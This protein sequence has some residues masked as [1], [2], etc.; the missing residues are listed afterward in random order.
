MNVWRGS[1]FPLT[2]FLNHT[3][4]LKGLKQKREILIPENGIQVTTLTFKHPFYLYHSKLAF[5][6]DK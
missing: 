2:E 5:T 6:E 3:G 4:R 1:L